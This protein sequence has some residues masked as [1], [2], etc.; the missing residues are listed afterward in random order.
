[1]QLNWENILDE[2]VKFYTNK[3]GKQVED[4]AVKMFRTRFENLVIRATTL[5]KKEKVF[6]SVTDLLYCNE[7]DFVKRTRNVGETVLE[8]LT[9]IR[10]TLVPIIAE[11]KK[12][13]EEDDRFALYKKKLDLEYAEY[14][15]QL[16]R[17]VASEREKMKIPLDY[18]ELFVNASTAATSLK[19]KKVYVD[20]TLLEQFRKAVVEKAIDV[21]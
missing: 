1:M 4:K 21:K 17:E 10:E 12:K 5:D 9:H 16:E 15:K 6:K 20:L 19:G 18:L 14:R 2:A 8:A 11:E 13:K 7:T 3:T